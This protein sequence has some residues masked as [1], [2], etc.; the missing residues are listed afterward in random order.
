LP[1]TVCETFY[2]IQ[3]ESTFAGWPCFFIRLSGCNLRCSY[4]DTTYAYT[5]GRIL[6]KEDILR[7]VEDCGSKIV[8]VTGGEPLLQT[9]TVL[10]LNT[11]AD[12]GYTVLLETN[13][14]RSLRDVPQEVVKIMDLKC[15]AS[16][17]SAYMDFKNLRYLDLKDQVKFV[18][19]DRSDYEWAREK[20]AKYHIPVYTQAVLSPVWQKMEAGTLAEW[21]LAD[22]LPARIQIQLHKYLWPDRERMV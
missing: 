4:C 6:S 15:P 18:I 19:Q 9:E 10:L 5:E 12:R 14:S 8:E 7:Q 16:G 11:L 3:G 2:S 13:G 17:M 20:M 1:L 22:R 21:M